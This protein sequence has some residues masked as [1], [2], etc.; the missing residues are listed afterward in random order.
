MKRAVVLL[1]GGI[2]SSTTLFLAKKN[3]YKVNCL[4]FDYGQRHE[5]EILSAKRIANFV[6]CKY[7]IIKIKLP[8]KG[9]SLLDRSKAVPERKD[10]KKATGIPSTYVPARNLIFLSFALSF[11]E[12][13]GCQAIFIG[14]NQ[15][16]YS[17]YP[18]CRLEFYKAL[19]SV[20]RKGTKAGVEGKLI[21]I[22]TPLIDKS[23]TEIIRLGLKLGVPFKLTWSCYKGK[24]LPCGKCDSCLLRRKGFNEADIKDPLSN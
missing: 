20:V 8:C 22:L 4:I 7:K 23:K 15:V 5:K 17:G 10:I 1:S 3:G 24:R 13:Q 2:D 14:A 19:K 21:K 6:G 11:A 12:S 18:D 9:S 16:D